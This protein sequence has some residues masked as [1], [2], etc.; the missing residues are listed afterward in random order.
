MKTVGTGKALRV[1]PLPPC[2][3]WLLWIYHLGLA[4]QQGVRRVNR[5]TSIWFHFSCHPHL[6]KL[7]LMNTNCDN[8][9][10]HTHTPFKTN[11]K[12]THYC[13]SQCKIILV[14]TRPCRS[15]LGIVTL[16]FFLH[17]T[18]ALLWWQFSV[19][20][21]QQQFQCWSWLTFSAVC[22]HR[23]KGCVAA[24][25]VKF[26]AGAAGLMVTCWLCLWGAGEQNKSQAKGTL[27]L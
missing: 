1:L 21:I 22:W 27:S 9:P 10:P 4:K 23:W 14:V 11:I 18:P 16:S 7:W 20:Q 25:G 6:Q 13:P 26:A 12:M 2:K 19:K 3:V 5:H 17:L 8:P 15:G 24:A